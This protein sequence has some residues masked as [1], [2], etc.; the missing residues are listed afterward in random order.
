MR[1]R[2]SEP[3]ART[4][5]GADVLCT[6]TTDD[7][8]REAGTLRTQHHQIL[9][10][11]RET[12]GIHEPGVQHVVQLVAG[13][14]ALTQLT[15]V[16]LLACQYRVRRLPL[17][18]H[19]PAAKGESRVRLQPLL[20][21]WCKV[22]AVVLALGGRRVPARP[23]AYVVAA[24]GQGVVD[25]VPGLRSTKVQDA[26]GSARLTGADRGELQRDV[27]QQLPVGGS[28]AVLVGFHVVRDQ[29]VRTLTRQVPG[30]AD[31]RHARGLVDALEAV[32]HVERL[33]GGAVPGVLVR[34]Q[35][36]QGGHSQ[37]D[38]LHQRGNLV[39]LRTACGHDQHSVR[40]VVDQAEHGIDC[41]DGGLR[42]TAL[43]LY[44]GQ[45]RAKLHVVRNVVLHPRRREAQNLHDVAHEGG[46][47]RVV[48]LQDR[49]LLAP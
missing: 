19:R 4:L 34:A 30:H 36:L 47:V 22:G 12:G 27:Q 31:T 35:A 6:H 9:R 17:V 33:Y 11:E 13:R 18:A 5:E 46:E 38:P 8:E 45:S 20:D 28:A 41:R 14:A 40:G 25:G 32:V 10:L 42:L 48:R 7:L 49:Q 21:A 23:D 29:Q 24:P 37:D 2:H 39:R 26:A 44:H 1:V 15:E 16:L 43:R 3:V